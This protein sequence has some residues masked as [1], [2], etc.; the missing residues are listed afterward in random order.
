VHAGCQTGAIFQERL[1]AFSSSFQGLLKG[2]LNQVEETMCTVTTKVTTCDCPYLQKRPWLLMS[3]STCHHYRNYACDCDCYGKF[4]CLSYYCYYF[5][6][7]WT[8][9]KVFECMKISKCDCDQLG[10]QLWLLVTMTTFNYSTFYYF[11]HLLNFL[12]Y[13]S[14]TTNY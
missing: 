3:A 5:Y 13:L 9:S 4:Y 6:N 2:M 14:T 8:R 11:H 7:Y 1:R 10:L 12:L